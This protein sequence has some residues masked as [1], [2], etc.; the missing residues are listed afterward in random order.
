MRPHVL[1]ATY[2]TGID[3]WNAGED[4]LVNK[5]D[6]HVSRSICSPGIDQ[7]EESFNF[8]RREKTVHRP[9]LLMEHSIY[10]L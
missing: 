5:L 3:T 4:V 8:V 7:S 9:N 1:V 6:R 2:V 10:D